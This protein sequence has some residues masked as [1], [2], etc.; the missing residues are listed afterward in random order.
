M[1]KFPILTLAWDAAAEWCVNEKETQQTMCRLPAGPG[2]AAGRAKATAECAN[3]RIV[4]RARRQPS[5]RTARE[6]SARSS[7]SLART[8]LGK[9]LLGRRRRFGGEPCSQH[10]NCEEPM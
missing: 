8:L 2:T 6:D 3:V 4:V 5:V 10:L 7:L 1:Q 9:W